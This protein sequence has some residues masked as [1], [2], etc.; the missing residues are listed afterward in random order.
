MNSIDAV[1]YGD[2]KPKVTHITDDLLR[3]QTLHHAKDFKNSW[4]KLGQALYSIYSDK[5]YKLWGY[6]KF[7]YYTEKEIGLKRQVAMK[8]LKTYYFLEHEEPEYLKDEYRETAQPAVVPSYETVNVL[9]LAKKN[10]DIPASEYKK[11]KIDVF[12][13]G[14]DAAVIR[15]DLTA[16]IRQREELDPDEERQK[17]NT[18]AV[19]R[20]LTAFRSFKKDMEVLKLLPPNLLKQTEDVMLKLEM[21]IQ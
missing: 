6:E 21:E 13:K 19:R 18:S 2:E 10:K 4:V 8:L 11:L 1:L 7:E 17:R 3:E 5:I 12:E 14:K 9:R 15:K 16:L 20:L